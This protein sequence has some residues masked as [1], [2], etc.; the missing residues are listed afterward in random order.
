MAFSVKRVRRSAVWAGLFPVLVGLC[1]LTGCLHKVLITTEP[2]G[3]TILVN[4]EEVGTSP[5]EVEERTGLMGSMHIRAERP[6]YLPAEQTV[7]QT[8]WFVW[9][10][11]IAVTPC[12]GAP[13]VLIPGCGPFIAVGW[14][15]FTSPTL[16]SLAFIRK[17]PD[18]VNLVLDPTMRLDGGHIVPTDTWIVPDDYVPNPLPVEEDSDADGEPSE[19]D[20][21]KGKEEQKKAAGE[22]VLY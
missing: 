7:E 20:P 15:L 2:E 6:N 12:L 16:I 5:V 17:S 8:E 22:T 11:L 19:D 21:D 10:G 13:T 9:P 18:E 4:G 3:A 1:L 14:A